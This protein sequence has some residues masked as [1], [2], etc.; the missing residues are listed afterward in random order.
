MTY[1]FLFNKRNT[2]VIFHYHGASNFIQRLNF[3]ISM[4][5][6]YKKISKM[7]VPVSYTALDQIKK[8]SKKIPPVKVIFNRSR[9]QF[10]Q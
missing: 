10:F 1:F 2:P 3:K 9:L 5:L 7:T 6:F 4:C 8:M